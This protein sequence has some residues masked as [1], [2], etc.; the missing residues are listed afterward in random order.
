M[1]FDP[2][3]GSES[4]LWIFILTVA[5]I[6]NVFVLKTVVFL[7]P[8]AH[9]HSSV[10][11]YDGARFCDGFL[12]RRLKSR[13]ALFVVINQLNA[14]TERRGR[15]LVGRQLPIGWASARWNRD[16][17]QVRRETAPWQVNERRLYSSSEPDD[18]IKLWKN[19]GKTETQLLRPLC[20]THSTTSGGK[21]QRK[22]IKLFINSKCWIKVKFNVSHDEFYFYSD[23][24]LLPGTLSSMKKDQTGPN[25]FSGPCSCLLVNLR[26]NSQENIQCFISKFKLF[27]LLFQFFILRPS[28]SK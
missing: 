10:W 12:W 2:G 8:S 6:I 27:I 23:L 21:P 16:E 4:S 15:S 5:L 26:K 13:S 1:T 11:R 7:K 3:D 14:Q 20:F 19:S 24:I 18:V 28:V 17:W 22:T 25:L 9:T